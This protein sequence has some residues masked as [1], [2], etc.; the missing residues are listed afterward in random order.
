[1]KHVMALSLAFALMPTAGL[2]S[3]LTHCLSGRKD[4][5]PWHWVGNPDG[6]GAVIFFFLAVIFLIPYLIVRTNCAF[7][8]KRTERRPR[9]TEGDHATILP[10]GVKVRLG[11]LGPSGQIGDV[12]IY[13]PPQVKTALFLSLTYLALHLVLSVFVCGIGAFAGLSIAVGVFFFGCCFIRAFLKPHTLWLGASSGICGLKSFELGSQTEASPFYSWEYG[14]SKDERNTRRLRG[15]VQVRQDG[16]REVV[17][18]GESMPLEVQRCFVEFINC[19]ARGRSFVYKE[20]RPVRTAE[21]N[22]QALFLVCAAVASAYLFSSYEKI[23]V[24]REVIQVECG[25]AVGM[26]ANRKRASTTEAMEVARGSG[27]GKLSMSERNA[28]IAFERA[29][30]W[31][32]L[33]FSRRGCHGKGLFAFAALLFFVAISWVGSLMHGFPYANLAFEDFAGCKIHNDRPGY[34]EGDFIQRRV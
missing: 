14:S 13:S 28:L 6:G 30:Q 3:V 23:T 4:V 5:A 24:D 29:G 34:W 10:E 27:L 12:M 22:V 20:H 15:S 18:F 31:Q 32:T 2:A 19:H 26:M 16:S 25:D 1:M 33:S 8:K 7:L 17:R 21:Q 11:A 9:A